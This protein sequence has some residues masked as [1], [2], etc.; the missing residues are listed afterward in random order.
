MRS[1]SWLRVA[2][3]LH[4]S[5]FSLCVPRSRLIERL[6]DGSHK[7][8]LT[9]TPSAGDRIADPQ[10]CASKAYT[11]NS[12]TPTCCSPTSTHL[13]TIQP[14]PLFV[15]PPRVALTVPQRMACLGSRDP[16]HVVRPMLQH[17]THKFLVSLAQPLRAPKG[18]MKNKKPV[19]PL[20]P[21]A[22]RAHKAK[23]KEDV[24]TKELEA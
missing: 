12:T 14:Y 8:S 18:L 21:K 17:G 22:R 6:C 20:K 15:V 9:Q 10:V 4:A 7:A 24:A 11:R 19:A 5:H 16:R 1:S 23:G 13:T 3:R 2:S